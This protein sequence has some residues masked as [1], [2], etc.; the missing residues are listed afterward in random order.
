MSRERMTRG[1]SLAIMGSV[2]LEGMDLA[3]QACIPC[4]G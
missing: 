1:P 3:T 2:A 4:R